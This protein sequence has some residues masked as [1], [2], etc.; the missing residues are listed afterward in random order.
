MRQGSPEQSSDQKGW[1][2]FSSGS[3][4][5]G[6][7]PGTSYQCHQSC[8]TVRRG[9]RKHGVSL[10]CT[11]TW[12]SWLWAGRTFKCYTF[13][14]KDT[15]YLIIWLSHER[16]NIPFVKGI[17]LF[18]VPAFFCFI[19]QKSHGVCPLVRLCQISGPNPARPGQHGLASLSR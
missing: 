13:Y 3:P 15:R 9:T 17:P 10:M 12:A 6:Y 11:S 5:N 2:Y 7:Q 14:S 8:G 4:A 18:L 19:F 16:K 1:R